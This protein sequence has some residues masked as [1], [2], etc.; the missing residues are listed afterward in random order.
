M[1]LC[2]LNHQPVQLSIFIP[3]DI[4]IRFFEFDNSGHNNWEAEGIFSESD[5]HHQYGIVFKTPPYRLAT[6]QKDVEV[7]VQLYRPSDGETSEE[8]LFYY[9]PNLQAGSKR[10]RTDH[11]FHLPTV[12]NDHNV[13]PG[14]SNQSGHIQNQN[15]CCFM[16]GRSN[17]D[18]NHQN[19]DGDESMYQNDNLMKCLRNLIES[20]DL[21][22]IPGSWD[23]IHRFQD[24]EG[25]ERLAFDGACS[26][27]EPTDVTCSLLDKIKLLIKLFN[28][29][30]DEKK[31]QEM[32]NVL[33]E[34]QRKSGENI[35]LD[36]IQY[37]TLEDI[38]EF[39][40]I[41]VK[42]KLTQELNSINDLDQNCVHLLIL[43]GYGKLLKIFLSLGV[44]VNQ[45]DAF[46]NSPL[47][48]AVSQND[49]ESVQELLRATTELQLDVINDDGFTSIHL[50][51]ANENLMIT[52]CL[53]EA[54]ADLRK[55]IPQT[56]ENVL[57][58][59]VKNSKINMPLINYLIE[60]CQDLLQLE[61][62]SG[63]NVLQAAANS[64]QPESLIAHLETLYDESYTRREDC[65]YD[66]S[67]TD[68]ESDTENEPS[69][70]SL[71]DDQ[72]I[73]ELCKI[74]DKDDKWKSMM[75][76]LELEEKID[77]WQVHV[78]PSKTLLKFIEVNIWFW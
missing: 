36:C 34:S 26:V 13:S 71:Y 33:I 46:G 31:L 74:L 5:V 40:L 30:F 54:G 10:P 27:E 11:D 9:K 75:L 63:L 44:N 51:V 2:K 76:L 39:V 55:V 22:D 67:T 16:G 52:E 65:D 59:A 77:E 73:R 32:I 64:S 21:G 29:N 70:P 12:L 66:D 61:N 7:R 23:E 50:A 19:N 57:H 47:H 14:P 1:Q 18:G 35:L 28:N 72:C 3:D 24:V 20:S 6:I 58:T 38:R 56:G 49:L 37:G 45:I 53:A 68:S 15:S 17:N 43:N 8:K 25:G 78:S 69:W 48:V 60:R 62:N 4:K 42:Y 41:L